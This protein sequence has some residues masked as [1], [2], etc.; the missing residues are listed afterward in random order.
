[1]KLLKLVLETTYSPGAVKAAAGA[2]KLELEEYS[3][4]LTGTPETGDPCLITMILDVP[5]PT[6]KFPV[7]CAPS[8]LLKLRLLE[9]TVGAA[10]KRRERKNKD[11]NKRVKNFFIKLVN[12]E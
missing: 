2:P 6:V 12:S 4:P 5:L 1:M 10:A 7:N 9:G 11:K 3:V 8:R